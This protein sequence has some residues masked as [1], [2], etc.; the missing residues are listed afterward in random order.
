VNLRTMSLWHW[1]LWLSDRNDQHACY[2]ILQLS[3][4]NCS[5]PMIKR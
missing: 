2:L 3:T 4:R 5:M 1:N